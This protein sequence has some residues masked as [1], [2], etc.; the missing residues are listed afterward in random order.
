MMLKIQ[1]KMYVILTLVYLIAGVG[2]MLLFRAF[3][4]DF[5][6]R[7]FLWIDLFFWV[8]GM[9]LNY[10]LDYQRRHKPARML[11]TYMFFRFGQ[12]MLMVAFLAVVAYA[13]EKV[14]RAPFAISLLG[15]Y[16][17]YSGLEIYMFYRYNKRAFHTK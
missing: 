5:E 10:M 3:S 16:L 11:N 7:F 12:F 17:V 4:E 9:T 2:S 8:C 1:V 15:N 14:Q 13:L 6:L